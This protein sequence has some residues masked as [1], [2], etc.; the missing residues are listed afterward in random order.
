MH[1]DEFLFLQNKVDRYD[2]KMVFLPVTED[3]TPIMQK[4]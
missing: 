1:E 3:I 4:C 2:E